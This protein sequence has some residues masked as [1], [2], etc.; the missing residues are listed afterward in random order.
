MTKKKKIRVPLRKNR[1]TTPRQRGKFSQQIDVREHSDDHQSRERISRKGAI[2][3]YRTI[4]SSE[5][6][7]PGERPLRDVDE[8]G[9]LMGRVLSPHGGQCLV[10]ADDGAIYQCAVR[11]LLKSLATDERG[12]IAAGD[13]VLF[14]P[15]GDAQGLIERVE[16]RHGVLTRMI[17]RQKHVLAANV[18]QVLIVASAA[19]PRLKPSLI[20]RYL[21]S[22]DVG[23]I[24]PLIAI[25]KADLTDLVELQPL[26]GTYAQLGY[27]IVPTSTRTGLGVARL[28]SLLKGRET[29]LAGQSGVGKTSLI[30]ALEPGLNLKTLEVTVESGKG[31]HTTTAARLL[32]LSLGGWVV[33]TPGIRQMELWD[34]VPDEVER[35]FLEFQPFLKDCRFPNCSH[36]HESRCGVKRAVVRGLVSILRYDSYCRIRTGDADE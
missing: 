34:V 16:P 1:Q 4:V 3:R 5:D 36:I 15:N 32:K 10:E 27:E 2:T 25:N 12:S 20:D 19:E 30:N 33:D 31:K 18:D 21:I 8:T 14:R 29:A 11:R 7:G 23:E 13:R 26:I 35:F 9:C 6:A 24:K 28:R 22:A 17:R